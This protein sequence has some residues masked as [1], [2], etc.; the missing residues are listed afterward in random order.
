MQALDLGLDAALAAGALEYGLELGVGEAG[1]LAG[2]WCVSQQGAGQRR[3]E[4]AGDRLDGGEV[5]GEVLAQVGAELVAGLGAVPDGVLLSAG[6]DGD[7]LGEF[8]VG[9][10]V[11]V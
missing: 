5:A 2:G 1:G 7:G 8:A 11:A 9:G 6:Q 10:Q 3:V 4:A